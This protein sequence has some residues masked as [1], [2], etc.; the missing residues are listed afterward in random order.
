LT[1]ADQGQIF[2]FGMDSKGKHGILGDAGSG[3]GPPAMETFDPQ[4]AAIDKIVMTTTGQSDFL[5]DGVFAGDAG[6]FTYEQVVGNGVKRSYPLLDPISH[7]QIAS[8]N[9][10]ITDFGIKQAA[11]NFDT[12]VGL[13]YGIKLADQDLPVLVVSDVAQNTI[14]NVIPLDTNSFGLSN[15]P[16]V[17]QDTINNR[18]IVVTSL[19]FG[20]AGGSPPVIFSI[21]LAS[22]KSVNVSEE[23]CPG[24]TNCGAANGA[25]FDSKKQIV[26]STNE[27]YPGVAFYNLQ[28]NAEN[29]VELPGASVGQ[30]NSA[31]TV[32]N[33]PVHHLFL[34]AQPESSIGSGSNIFVYDVNGNLLETLSRF[35]FTF[36]ND[37]VGAIQIALDPKDRMGYVNGPAV[38][39]I[40]RF[41]Y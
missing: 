19:S 8:W 7:K 24:L 15:G 32:V 27:I 35:N 12:S 5:A 17:A 41:T 34:V 6:L 38:N 37:I 31:T 16:N 14:S 13:I 9:S 18:A 36:A 30:Y 4:T 11:Q 39:Q 3:H 40:Q 33:D 25:A 23:S 28:T 2:G 10:P 26:A 1:S 21:D 29:L 22:G 20:A